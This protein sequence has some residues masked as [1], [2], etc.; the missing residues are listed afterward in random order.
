MRG[1]EARVE[2]DVDGCEETA[3][4]ERRR[5]QRPDAERRI[6]ADARTGAADAWQPWLLVRRPR[7]ARVPAP[8][9]GVDRLRIQRVVRI[10]VGLAVD[11]DGRR[12]VAGE[13]RGVTPAGRV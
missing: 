10:A 11:R 4:R 6:R 1:G 12:P 9:R 8:G 7:R 2:I 13:P 3:M 5:A